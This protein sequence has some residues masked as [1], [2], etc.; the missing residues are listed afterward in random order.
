MLMNGKILVETIEKLL[1]E[2]LNEQEILDRITQMEN[3]G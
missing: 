1:A 2:G 3:K